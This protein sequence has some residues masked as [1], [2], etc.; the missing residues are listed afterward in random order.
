MLDAN[1]PA[2]SSSSTPPVHAQTDVEPTVMLDVNTP[3]C[4][5]WFENSVMSYIT[6]LA[7]A[8]GEA[9]CRAFRSTHQQMAWQVVSQLL[10]LAITKLST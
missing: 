4:R 9:I 3:V 6:R 8:L 1:T 10:I 2:Q 7:A 5:D